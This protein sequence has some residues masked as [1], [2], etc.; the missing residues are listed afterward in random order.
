MSSHYLLDTGRRV[1]TPRP[2]G[3]RGEIPPGAWN[4][5]LTLSLPAQSLPGCFSS[6]LSSRALTEAKTGLFII[7]GSTWWVCFSFKLQKTIK[8]V[9]RKIQLSIHMIT[10][11][12][13]DLNRFP[14]VLPCC[15]LNSAQSHAIV[16]YSFEG[17]FPQMPR[18][19]QSLSMW[20]AEIL[21]NR[22]SV[23]ILKKQ[24]TIKNLHNFMAIKYKMSKADPDTL[25]RSF[26]L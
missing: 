2:G 16:V 14:S 22:T 3:L 9:W 21:L 23:F 8:D 24:P 12:R 10:R 6:A 18:H 26:L 25:P 17:L 13:R 11:A 20:H 4:Q 19:H 1:Q 15:H 5:L 7:H